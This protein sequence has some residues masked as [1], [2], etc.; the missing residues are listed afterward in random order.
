MPCILIE[1]DCE[2]MDDFVWP[3][4]LHRRDHPSR[5]HLTDCSPSSSSSPAYLADESR[6][7]SCIR[8]LV[9]LWR[10]HIRGTMTHMMVGLLF[11]KE[12][13]MSLYV[14][15]STRSHLVGLVLLICQYQKAW[16]SWVVPLYL[17]F[18]NPNAVRQNHLYCRYKQ[19]NFL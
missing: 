11:R 12:K 13:F 3:C 8:R 5:C 18:R 10:L 16:G 4:L 2:L 19:L 1:C 17:E 7:T 9:D 14:V 6:M 15:M